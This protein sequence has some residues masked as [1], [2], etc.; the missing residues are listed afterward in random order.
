MRESAMGYV[1]RV[2]V[3]FDRSSGPTIFTG[4]VAHT[5]SSAVADMADEFEDMLNSLEEVQ[6]E[7]N[8]PGKEVIILDDDE[9][10]G[11]APGTRPAAVASVQNQNR[12]S[13]RGA[14]KRRAGGRGGVSGVDAVR[15]PFARSSSEKLVPLKADICLDDIPCVLA[16]PQSAKRKMNPAVK[17]T[18]AGAVPVPLWP[19]YSL[20]WKGEPIQGQKWIT[21]GSKEYWLV[22][23]C[24]SMTNMAYKDVVKKVV[25]KFSVGLSDPSLVRH[26]PSGR[27]GIRSCE[28]V[29]G[30]EWWGRGKE[31][32]SGWEVGSG[33]GG[34]EV[35]SSPPP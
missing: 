4:I 21:V 18:V 32:R 25:D 29:G 30:R 24:D 3:E 26:A 15:L 13:G 23:L 22:R 7:N 19:Q 27:A 5:L 34:A 11:H 8:L 6:A 2:P 9:L 17:K 20:T 35:Q 28:R 12:A 31:V 33:L 10:S 14:R 16:I 1:G